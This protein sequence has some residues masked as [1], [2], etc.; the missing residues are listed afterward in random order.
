MKDNI[1]DKIMTIKDVLPKKQKILCDF[2]VLNYSNAGMMTV[3]EIAEASGV[4]TTT[5]MRLIK[6]LDYDNYGDFK[7]D[8]LEYSIAKN[9]SSYGSIKENFKD[10]VKDDKKDILSSTCL[11]TIHA[12]ENFITQK[13]ISQIDEAVKLMIKSNFINILG[14]RSSKAVAIYMECLVDRFCPKIKQL[15]NE[16]EFLYD[17]ALR[18]EDNEVLVIFSIWPCTKKTIDIADICNKRGVKIIL[19]T[20]TT[21]NPIARYADIIIDTNSVNSS[22]GNLPAMFVVEALCSELYKETS[23]TSSEK[24][25]ELE[26]QLDDCDIFVWE[27]KL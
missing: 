11:K 12:V 5:V 1:I 2:I 22:V 9:T 13:N 16:S 23:P 20:N 17:K 24:I 26:K 18:V 10:I 27:S 25:E 3:A 21:L 4:G 14:L 6:T 7:H 8:L 19:V 15:S